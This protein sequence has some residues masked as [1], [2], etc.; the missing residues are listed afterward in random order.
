VNDLAISSA[1]VRGPAS[2]PAR[3]GAGP[4][5]G[6]GAGFGQALGQ[7]LAEVNRLHTDSQD[8]AARLAAGQGNTLDVVVAVQK[9]D[10][11]F[12]LVVQI[13]NKLL[14]AYQEV[15]RMQV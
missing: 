11:A 8:A 15:M 13:R 14:E 2:L 4:E 6:G 1:A 5:A 3:P 7:A 9:A 10:V 12:Q